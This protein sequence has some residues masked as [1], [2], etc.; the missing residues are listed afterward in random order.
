MLKSCAA[1]ALSVAALT[2][3]VLTAAPASADTPDCV[4][5]AEFRAVQRKWSQD[6]VINRFDVP[7]RQVWFASGDPSLDIPASQSRE[8]R[9]CSKYSYVSVSFERKRGDVWRVVSRTAYWAS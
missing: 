5:K 2:P 8:Y 7:G 3:V 6:R 9:P 4:S 1:A